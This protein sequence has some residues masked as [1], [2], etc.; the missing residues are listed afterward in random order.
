MFKTILNA[1]TKSIRNNYATKVV[2]RAEVSSIQDK[3]DVS[4][5][6]LKSRGT[7]AQHWK[8]LRE[9]LFASPANITNKNIDTFI[10]GSYTTENR[11]ADAKSYID[12][13]KNE[14]IKLNLAT[15]GRC[16]K[17]HYLMHLEGLSTKIDEDNIIEMYENVVKEYPMLDSIT[18]EN[19][20]AGLSVTREWKKCFEIFQDLKISC[21]PNTLAYNSLISAAFNHD[22]F[23]TGWALFQEMIENNRTPSISTYSTYLERLGLSDLSKLDDL[24]ENVAF[25]NLQLNLT[26]AQKIADITD[27]KSRLPRFLKKACVKVNAFFENV[28]IG[29]DVFHKT[30]PEELERFKKFVQNMGKFDVIVDG[31]NV[32]YS[33]GVKQPLYMQSVLLASVVAHFTKQRKKVLVMGRTHMER[34][35]QRN[36]SF[37]KKNSTVF[38]INNISQDDPYLL[39]CGLHCGINTIIVTRDFMRSHLYLLRDKQHKLLFNRWL[40]Q[41]RYHLVHADENK[42]IFKTPLPYMITP[43]KD[44][45][46]WHVPYVSE[47]TSEKDPVYKWLCIN[48]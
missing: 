35:P 44:G 48:S 1:T 15:I 4:R 5:L 24:L 28:I 25:Y 21:T 16:F 6:I 38:L 30:T 42:A 17:L 33:A 37:I 45:N 32:V 34:Y 31:L 22:E 29:K 10:I 18:G 43:Q 3:N 19:I 26:I 36:W 47:T 7:S 8:E 9:K 39:Y 13:L 46:S 40:T 41:S 23:I 2:K 27:G 20:I 14:K 12:Y 11:Y